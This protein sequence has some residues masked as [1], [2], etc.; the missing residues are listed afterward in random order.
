MREELL[1]TYTVL[2]YIEQETSPPGNN[3]SP[4]NVGASDLKSMLPKRMF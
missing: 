4:Q 3:A 1:A 2:S